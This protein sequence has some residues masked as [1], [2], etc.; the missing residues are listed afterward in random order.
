MTAASAS[1]PWQPVPLDAEFSPEVAALLLSDRGRR[2]LSSLLRSRDEALRTKVRKHLLALGWTIVSRRNAAMAPRMRYQS[3]PRGNKQLSKSYCS[4]PDL[5]L[6]DDPPPSASSDETTN[7]AIHQDDD[8]PDD[9]P[10]ASRITNHHPDQPASQTNHHPS[11]PGQEEDDDKAA[12]AEYVALMASHDRAKGPRAARLRA[13]TKRQ[14]QASGWTFWIKLK[15]DG[16]EELRYKAPTGRSYASLHTA[17]QAFLTHAGSPGPAT[18]KDSTT[19]VSSKKKRKSISSELI[20]AGQQINKC[21]T[22]TTVEKKRRRKTCQAVVCLIKRST[23]TTTTTTK[24]KNKKQAARALRPNNNNCEA[25]AA[26]AAACQRRARTLLSVLIDEDILVPRD[27]VTYRAASGV[28]KDGLITGDGVR[29]TCCNRAFT[30]AEFEAHATRGIRTGR[31]W[32]R[33]FLKKDGRSLSQCLLELMRRDTNNGTTVAAT[34][35]AA[36]LR[37]GRGV[38]RLKEECLDRDGDS[39]CSMCNDGGEL[40]LCDHCP[41]AFH[42][43]CLGLQATPEAGDS[44]FC[45]CCRCG[46][47]GDSDFDPPAPAAAAAD[48][49]RRRRLSDRN[50]IYCEQCER[51]YHV[52]CVLDRGR[53]GDEGRPWLCSP[54]CER[55]FRHLQGLAGR[56]IPTSAEGVSLTILR[57]RR[58]SAAL[59]HEHHDDEEEE[60]AIAAAEEHGKLRAALDVL[61]ECFVP[62]VEPRT[63]SDLSADIVFN[64][65][66][67]LRRLHFRGYYVVG[68]EK[69]GELVTVGTLRVYGNK[70]AELPL[71]G[72]RFA[73]RR[74]G[75]CHLLVRE[76]DGVLGGEL[77]VHRLVLPAVPELLHMWTSSS[78]GFKAMTHS[79]KLEMAEHTILCFQGTTMCQ[80]PLAA[81]AAASA[82]RPD[83]DEELMSGPFHHSAV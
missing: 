13:G 37:G 53:V 66:S 72:T 54:G 15:S 7:S 71:V 80:K 22:T 23:T 3:P 44:W 14:L 49:T 67:E 59:L 26:A 6:L 17:C 33:L 2:E 73:H 12:I 45:P 31:P 29:C 55:V 19:L 38:M 10:P 36:S 35:K 20:S 61:H 42:H 79:D 21:T 27:K 39:V 82:S 48:G 28:S 25:E 63:Q 75:M 30:V 62:L 34:S 77:G 50:I 11:E 9:P 56:S 46:V 74:Q 70:V 18:H 65:E 1:T 4:L 76:L 51:E 60:A 47:C 43:D 81:A 58:R 52:G 24:R 68:L 40:L 69:G 5:I 57:R 16:R 41:S 64:R 83:D 78:M 8:H 32:A